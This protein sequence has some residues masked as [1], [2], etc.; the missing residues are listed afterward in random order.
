[1]RLK[2]KRGVELICPKHGAKAL[3]IR[4][5]GPHA[6]HPYIVGCKGKTPGGRRTCQY[7]Q[8]VSENQVSGIRRAHPNCDAEDFKESSFDALF[9]II[10]PD[11]PNKPL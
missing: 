6:D 11:L 5:C 1:M 3:V 4:G 9:E 8:Y 2:R 7:Y 10:D